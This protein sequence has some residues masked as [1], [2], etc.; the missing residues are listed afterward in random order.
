MFVLSKWLN[1]DI[2]LQNHILEQ[3]EQIAA[4]VDFSLAF[5]AVLK[6]RHRRKIFQSRALA[7][8]A[9]SSQAV[10]LVARARAQGPELRR[11]PLMVPPRNSGASGH[12]RG[13]TRTS[14]EL[15]Y[16]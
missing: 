6:S 5:L 13:D 16:R 7:K 12:H 9:C 1:F 10:A 2:S 3:I 8:R 15:T 11:V 14:L 4:R